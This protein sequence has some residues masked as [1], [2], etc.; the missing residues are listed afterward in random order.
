[1]RKIIALFLHPLRVLREALTLSLLHYLPL[2]HFSVV[3]PLQKTAIASARYQE[4][5]VP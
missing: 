3:V 2:A 5:K 1:M 4:K